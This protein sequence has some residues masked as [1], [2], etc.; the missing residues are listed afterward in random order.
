[1]TA[2][3]LSIGDELLIGQVVNSNATWLGEKLT[4]SGVDVQRVVTLSD[5]RLDIQEAVL[6]AAT[7]A[8]LVIVTGGLGPTHDDIT[9]AAIAELYGVELV[10][11]QEILDEL[12]ARYD[13]AGLAMSPSN[14]S[15]AEVP[16]GF[17]V[18]ANRHGSA[19][20][21]LREAE[22]STLVILPGVPREM[23]DLMEEHI[24]P[25]IRARADRRV[26]V[27]RSLL[28]TGI[29]ESRLHDS[30][31]ELDAWLA[32]GCLL[33]Y[34]PSIHGVRMRITASGPDEAAARELAHDFETYIRG[35]AGRYIYGVDDQT[36]EGAVGR[37]LADIG[38]SVGTAESCTGGLVASRLTDVAGSSAYVLGSVVAYDDKIKQSVLGVDEGDLESFGAVSKEVVAA[39]AEGIRSV[40]GADVG[41]AVSGIMGPGGGTE[42]K[43]VGTVWMAVVTPESRRVIRVGL[44]HDRLE[45]KARSATAALNL[46]RL[47]L[48]DPLSD[49]GTETGHRTSLSTG[50]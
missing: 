20:G 41:L 3:I 45:N 40:M 38:W 7:R 5:S 14:R 17:E 27:R 49:D 50:V 43:P 11:H 22:G 9:K 32:R 37:L 4:D 1:M 33:A 35:H 39:M 30:L 26:V 47:M 21:L 46:L 13:R 10:F 16:R 28:T 29:A 2:E 6:A 23:K 15:Q 31:G 34:L 25:R 44:R 48:I 18:L 8:D 19:P 12:R 42:E 24:L 36:L